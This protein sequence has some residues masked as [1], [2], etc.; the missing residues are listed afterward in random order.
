MIERYWQL[1]PP[2]YDSDYQDSII[3][4]SGEHPYG[5]PGVRCSACGQ[6]WAGSYTLPYECPVSLRKHKHLI[7]GWPIPESDHQALQ[8]IVMTELGRE[9]IVDAHLMPG[10]RFQPA[11]LKFGS[12]PKS[13][14]LWA[15]IGSAIVS[16]KTKKVFEEAGVTGV[17]F[18]PAVINK[19]GKRDAIGPAPI[20]E[21][22]E[23]ED[24]IEEAEPEQKS[25]SFGPLY[26]MVILGES[27][28]PPG[29]E[30]T[31]RCEGCG[32]EEY[33]KYKRQ[34]VLT[35]SMIPDSDVFYMATTLYIY[36]N[37]KVHD[38]I[39]RHRLTNIELSEYE[40]ED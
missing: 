25:E 38:L 27:G 37:Q 3:N 21:T 13:D 11:R 19:V 31:S 4:G 40:L 33:D 22:G 8:Q 36:V 23:P 7:D 35:S 34:L 14:F 6:T 12:R 10:I 1:S 26:E 16:P 30:I 24:I 9:G 28:Q 39:L 20:P 29:A 2:E 15:T 18:C 32:R 5:L 17:R